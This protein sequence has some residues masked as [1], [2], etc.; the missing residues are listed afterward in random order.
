MDEIDSSDEERKMETSQKN[1][2]FNHKKKPSGIGMDSDSDEKSTKQSQK[3]KKSSTT[4]SQKKIKS[5]TKKS[6]KKKESEDENIK[7]QASKAKKIQST[8]KKIPQK[9]KIIVLY[10]GDLL[11]RTLPMYNSVQFQVQSVFE[12]DNMNS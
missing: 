8:Q 6:Q 1:K 10:C 2:T 3:K 11:T 12:L 7:R 5:S 4:Q 9:V